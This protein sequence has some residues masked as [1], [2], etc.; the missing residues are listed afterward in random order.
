M[1]RRLIYASDLNPMW[2]TNSVALTVVVVVETKH[3][4][5]Q[6]LKHGIHPSSLKTWYG[7]PPGTRERH[8]VHIALHKGPLDQK[9]IVSRAVKG[10]MK[11]SRREDRGWRW[12]DDKTMGPNNVVAKGCKQS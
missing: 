9:Q 11:G 5:H 6:V 1:A 7:E 10:S 4:E 12:R 3:A 2:R 8:T